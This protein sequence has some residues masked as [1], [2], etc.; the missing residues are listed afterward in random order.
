MR[1]FKRFLLYVSSVLALTLLVSAAF[2]LPWLHT[3]TDFHDQ[4][5]RASLSG[6]ID[7]LVI[8]QSYTLNGVMPQKLD[9][10]LG[11]RTY[12]LSG[13]LMPLYGQHYLLG[14]ELARNPIRHV[15]LEITPDTFTG[16][17]RRTYGNGDSY[18]IARLDS[19]SERVDYLMRCVPLSDWPNIYAR[20]LLQSMRSAAYR[21]MGR[22]ECIDPDN[23]GFTPQASR[24]VSLHV[25]TVHTSRQNLS[26]F[27]AP[28]DE[29]FSRFE[30]IIRLCQDA[31]CEVTLFYTPISNAKLWTLYDQDVFYDRVRSLAAEY[32]V[33]LFDFNLLRTRCELF[34]D[35][36]AF[37]DQSHL[38]GEGAAVFSE[39]MADVLARYRAGED[40]SPL[41]YDNYNEAI[42]SSVYWG[43]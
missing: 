14:K 19:L 5:L 10:R 29:N 12:N 37:S 13:S 16:D 28:L 32:G 35:A 9:A 30:A 39:A 34:P 20:L 25:D 7:T 11:T 24:D 3:P 4:A 26:I 38:S 23:L 43:I 31:G 40:V 33:A 42:H 41:F 17:E 1:I 8:G 6:Q 18:I 22:M 36:S 27:H 15:L 2:I 21:L